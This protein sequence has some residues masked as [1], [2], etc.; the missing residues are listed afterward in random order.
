[1][2]RNT[3]GR[4]GPDHITLAP[5][6]IEF[7]RKKFPSPD[8]RF[9]IEVHER[10]HLRGSGVWREAEIVVMT[11][12]VVPLSWLEKMRHECPKEEIP[13]PEATCWENDYRLSRFWL[14][15]CLKVWDEI[16]LEFRGPA[17]APH[18]LEEKVRLM[19][20]EIEKLRARGT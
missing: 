3:I 13:G 16:P 14:S 15:R 1:M 11:N 7:L 12:H 9:E 4:I 19:V 17:I 8:Y 2:V 20:K 5:L 18:T 6:V 10:G